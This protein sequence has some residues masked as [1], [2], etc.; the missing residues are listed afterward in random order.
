MRSSANSDATTSADGTA[1]SAEGD[2]IGVGIAIT[3]TEVVNTAIIGNNATVTSNGATV[4]AVMT[5]VSGNSEHLFKAESKSGSSA[6]DIGVAGSF[7]LGIYTVTTTARL[8]TGA[9]L[10]ADGNDDNAAT[11][12]VT[13]NAESVSSS[14]VK[15]EPAEVPATPIPESVG[16]GASIAIAVVNDNA[17]ATI[18][19][20]AVLSDA[21]DLTVHAKAVHALVVIAK[22]GAKSAEVAVAPAVGVTIH[23]VSSLATIG[24]L[25]SGAALNLTG[26]LD[27]EAELTASADTTAQGDTEG[28]DASVGIAIALTFA[29]HR[30]ES[31]TNRTS[32]Q[33]AR[34]RSRRSA[35]RSP[36]RS[37]RRPPP[38]HRARKMPTTTARPTTPTATGTQ[39]VRRSTSRSRPS[40]APPTA[41][42]PTPARKARETP[43][44]P[45]PRTPAATA[46]RLPRRSRSTSPT[47]VFAL[48]HHR[49]PDGQCGWGAVG[50]VLGQLRRQG[51]RRRDRQDAGEDS[52]A[53]GVGVAINLP[54]SPTAR[55]SATAPAPR[56]T[57]WSSRP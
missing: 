34:S 41:T 57:A 45:A 4:E 55:P 11:D 35:P 28:D 40:V 21:A 51:H 46:S 31:G 17:L 37:R 25:T 16:V 24:T 22:T 36:A 13:I 10:D 7:S 6:G 18:E 50:A 48:L 30:V 39:T 3:Y 33:L 12:D 8:S 47:S 26:A 54:T 20:N 27:A 42:P 38:A 44:L 52:T 1:A 2:A 9:S 5:D 43:R 32:R 49:R 56:P 53:V 15:A 23:N 19:D 14:T 29:D